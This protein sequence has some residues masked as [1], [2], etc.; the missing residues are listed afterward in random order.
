MTASFLCA[1]CILLAVIESILPDVVLNTHPSEPTLPPPISIA[2]LDSQ[3]SSN[4]KL[5]RRAAS[6]ASS[7]GPSPAIQDVSHEVA[8][9]RVSNLP[10]I[11]EASTTSMDESKPR[12]VRQMSEPHLVLGF[13][14]L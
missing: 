2:P 13:T 6:R 9:T 3:T 5:V 11:V 8:H 7:R 10:P 14:V 1:D 4:K 12:K